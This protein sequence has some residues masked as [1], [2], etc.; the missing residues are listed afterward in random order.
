MLLLGNAG[1]IRDQQYQYWTKPDA[2]MAMHS[3]YYLWITPAPAVYRQAGGIPFTATFSSSMDVQGVPLSTTSIIDV[4]G[5]T[6]TT[7]V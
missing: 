5:V 4:Q 3:G 1:L 2:E 7:S 6:L